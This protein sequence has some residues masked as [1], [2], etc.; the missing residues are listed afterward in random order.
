MVELQRQGYVQRR[1]RLREIDF[2]ING[3]IVA[4][5]LYWL[6]RGAGFR[7]EAFKEVSMLTVRLIIGLCVLMVWWMLFLV[8][9]GP[10]V[11]FTVRA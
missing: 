9:L 5:F 3:V 8:S 2:A 7:Q 10:V 4:A 6:F 1:T 11:Y